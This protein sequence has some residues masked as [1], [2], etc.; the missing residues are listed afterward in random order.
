MLSGEE[1]ENKMG[2]LPVPSITTGLGVAMLG[3]RV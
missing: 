3:P 2:N 1:V